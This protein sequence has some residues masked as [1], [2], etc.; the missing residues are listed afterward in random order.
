MREYWYTP[1]VELYNAV[2]VTGLMIVIGVL[3]RDVLI[4]LLPFVPWSYLRM[5]LDKYRP[6]FLG[7]ERLR[8]VHYYQKIRWNGEEWED[9]KT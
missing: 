1:R 6:P 4:A 9:V 2:L 5:W 3:T 7:E 8:E